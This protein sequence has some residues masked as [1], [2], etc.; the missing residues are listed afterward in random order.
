MEFQ[1]PKPSGKNQNK[2]TRGSTREAHLAN[3]S[4]D[5]PLL[6]WQGTH[7]SSER[8]PMFAVG[9]APEGGWLM[10]NQ[11]SNTVHGHTYSGN[12]SAKVS[13]T[14]LNTPNL[15]AL[16]GTL[17]MEKEK[18]K[19]STRNKVELLEIGIKAMELVQGAVAMSSKALGDSSLI[20]EP[21]KMITGA[22]VILKVCT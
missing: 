20:S 3:G 10:P 13:Q 18:E 22:L 9:G 6:S 4:S 7:A 11:L 16:D 17:A 2:S 19:N 5:F 8:V 15:S 14:V 12:G 21:L 1:P